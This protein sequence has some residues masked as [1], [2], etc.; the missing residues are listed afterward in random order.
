MFLHSGASLHGHE[1]SSRTPPNA[2]QSPAHL[3]GPLL[4]SAFSPPKQRS[5]V[6]ADG[7]RSPVLRQRPASD[8]IP[9]ESS[10]VVRF[11]E[12]Q[13]N[14]DSLP[15]TPSVN[16][17]PASE[18]ELSD[19]TS[20]DGA[21]FAPSPRRRRTRRAART[22]TTYYL[23]Y[24]APRIIG[25]TKVVR[26]VF[27]PRLLL[28]LQEVSAEGRSKPVLEVFPASRIAGPARSAKRF[29]GIS[30]VKRHLG[31]DDI[32][33]VRR[34]DDDTSGDGTESDQEDSMD[35]RNPVAVYS[36]LKHSEEAEIVLDDGSVWLAKLLPNG[37]FD[38]VYTDSGGETT[39]VRW[40]RRNPTPATTPTT[41]A[42]SSSVASQA[43]YTFSII[44][45]LTRRHPVMATLT[46]STLEVQDTYTSVSTSH[47][48]HPP[49]TR[50]SR[51]QSV[52]SSPSFTR[53]PPYSPSNISSVGSTSTNDSEND[54]GVWIPSSPS[55]ESRRTTHQID[56]ATK[57]LISVTALWVCLRAGW[58]QSYN[59]IHATAHS[60]STAAS[61]SSVTTASHRA[62]R[63]RRNT[64]TTRSST[65]DTPRPT[66]RP[67][68]GGGDPSRGFG[69]DAVVSKGVFKRHS[70]PAQSA[71]TSS[72]LNSHNTSAAP[73]PVIS[74]ASTPV[75]NAPTISPVPAGTAKSP[76]RRAISST[77][78]AFIRGRRLGSSSFSAMNSAGEEEGGE[79]IDD[80]TTTTAQETETP[81]V[82]V[83]PKIA[84]APKST[85][86]DKTKRT[87]KEKEAGGLSLA[88]HGGDSGKAAAAAKKKPGMRSRLARWFHKLGPTTSR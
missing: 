26:K 51:S 83:P 14:D 34:D 3:R 65:S 1:Y 36:P 32:V 42:S 25:K 82:H 81:V 37:C 19:V 38:F 18:S 29:P 67:L 17:E 59:S 72:G 54:S 12:P 58:S 87:S 23:G 28:Q 85:K 15:P 48:R 75:Q 57:S 71:D 20:L 16:D 2:A 61:S 21:A 78:T 7:T 66:D 30:E 4:R 13:D 39:N 69:C 27:L 43:R 50:A 8:Y 22:S 40:A 33:L 45:P 47:A 31:F 60:E 10:A 62:G 52:T 6:A 76:P 53:T 88:G 79:V 11:Q 63:S 73:T 49:V 68:S 56:E 70:L 55:Y 77:G 64:W 86:K 44:N 74:R 5:R 84:E 41:D 80:I 24:P 35:W 9:R 46:P